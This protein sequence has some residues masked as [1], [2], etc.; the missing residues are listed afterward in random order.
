MRARIATALLAVMV[1]GCGSARFIGK[2][3]PFPEGEPTCASMLDDG[4]SVL[5]TARDLAAEAAAREAVDGAEAADY[6]VE[7]VSPLL[8]ADSVPVTVVNEVVALVVDAFD[9]EDAAE[10]RLDVSSFLAAIVARFDTPGGGDLDPEL[11]ASLRWVVL[12]LELGFREGA[13][14]PP[15]G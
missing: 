5:A 8:A 7:I 6:M 15:L 11:Q 2:T 3:G 10:W 13:S 9:P 14:V 4:R 1:A 12:G